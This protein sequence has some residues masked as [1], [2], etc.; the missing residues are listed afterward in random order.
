VVF[1]GRS[2]AELRRNATP[3]GTPVVRREFSRNEQLL[4]RFDAYGSASKPRAAL[5]NQDGD[6]MHEIGVTNGDGP[7]R[8]EISPAVSHLATGDYVLEIA[9]SDDEETRALVPIKIRR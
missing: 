4:V 6:R 3:D 5:L 7:G 8:Y 1:A 9:L 2:A